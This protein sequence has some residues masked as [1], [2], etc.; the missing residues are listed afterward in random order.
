MSRLSA[1]VVSCMLINGAQGPF[2]AAE[3]W[4]QLLPI[5]ELV[6]N[7]QYP[8]AIAGYEKY[9]QQAPK[10]LRGPVT[11]EIAT[12]HSA[13]GNTERALVMLEQAIQ[14]GFDDC[15][16]IQQDADLKPIRNDPRFQ[17]LYSRVRISGAD[18]KEL[19][20]LKSEVQNISHD[21]KMMITE[22]TARA[23]GG[24]TIFTQSIIPI[25][26]TASPGVLFKREIVKVAQQKQREYV[27][28]AD[29]AR[30][31]HLT[32]MT[33]ISGG[34]SSERAAR[35]S[36]IARRAAEERMRAIDARKFSLA[37]EAGATPRPC[38]E[39]K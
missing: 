26:E 9:L 34:A 24:S 10:A 27:L 14:S 5:L 31:G 36:Y 38:G 17:E 33:I 11:F 30:I 12:M 15:I 28:A 25:R 1:L 4:Q 18:L 39:W 8:E 35:S 22:N 6:G 23:D 13:L 16:A 19:Y 32:R 29:K 21:T 3:E 7:K 37:P 20:W 2:V